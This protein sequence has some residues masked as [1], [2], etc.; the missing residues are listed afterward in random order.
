MTEQITNQQMDNDGGKTQQGLTGGPVARQAALRT[1][2]R[3]APRREAAA[4][5]A[6]AH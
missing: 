2:A 3:L 4:R 6:G 5:T 1:P